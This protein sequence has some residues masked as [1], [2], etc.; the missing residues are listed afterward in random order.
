[1]IRIFYRVLFV[2]FLFAGAFRGAAQTSADVTIWIVDAELA[3]ST[4]TDDGESLDFDF[5]E[6]AGYGLSFN[7]FWTDRFSTEFA[8]QKYD[9]DMTI[10]PAGELSITAGELSITSITAIAQWHFNRDGRFSPYV[11]GGAAHVGGEFEVA[12]DL[13]TEEIEIEAEL[14]WT[15]SWG[16][17]SRTRW[18]STR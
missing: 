14:T 9:A 4:I 11:G 13:E 12:D 16:T 7:R 10:T 2:L 15:I 17:W 6:S 18:R 8:L 1:M 3:E 5:E